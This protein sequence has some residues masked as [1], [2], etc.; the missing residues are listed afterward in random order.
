M[1]VTPLD[2]LGRDAVAAKGWFGAH[3]YLLAR[4]AVQLAI[5]GLFMLGPVAGFTILKGNLSAS[6]LFETIPM[7]DPLLFL[8]MLAA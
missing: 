5:L 2:E 8:Q 7:T 1:P 6:L 3:K 4:R